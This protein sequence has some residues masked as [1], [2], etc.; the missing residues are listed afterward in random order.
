MRSPSGVKGPGFLWAQGLSWTGGAVRATSPFSLPVGCSLGVARACP[1]LGLG[2]VV[3]RVG[4]QRGLGREG[5]PPIGCGQPQKTGLG[6]CHTHT[7]PIWFHFSFP[8][9]RNN[10][11]GGWTSVVVGGTSREEG[12]GL[13]EGE[14]RPAGRGHWRPS[15]ASRSL[16]VEVLVRLLRAREGGLPP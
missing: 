1:V 2:L 14:R 12:S 5:G 8:L 3:A 11:P 4:G 10:W 6:I 13:G 7:P 15:P 16:L 9:A